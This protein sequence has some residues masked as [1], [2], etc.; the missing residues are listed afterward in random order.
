MFSRTPEVLLE[1][2]L[3][4]QANIGTYKIAVGVT[5]QE[6]TDI[7]EDAANL[8]YIINFA[9]LIEANKRGVFQIKNAVYNG[10]PDVPVSDFPEFPSAAPPFPLRAGIEARF[11]KRNARFKTAE[12]YTKEIGIALGIEQSEGSAPSLGDMTAALKP[13]DLGGYQYKVEFQK[14]GQSAMLVQQRKKG[15]EKWSEAKTAL[16]SPATVTVDEPETE[17]AAVQLEIRGR[18]M[19]GNEQIGQWSPIY[20]VTVN[21]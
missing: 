2:L 17:G 6:Q 8:Q 5:A 14:Q 20:T 15:A 9:D 11:N 19:K 4:Q 16:T 12:G 13:S 21:P 7:T 10:D 1:R 3:L 18:L